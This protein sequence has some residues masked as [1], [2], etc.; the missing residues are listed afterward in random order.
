MI[1][2]HA[3]ITIKRGSAGEFEAALAG[4]RAIIAQA[5]GF[6]FLEWYR[7]I[8]FPEKYLLR[9]G[10]ETLEDHTVGFRQSER[11]AQ[12]RALIG[13]FFD[14]PPQVVHFQPI[15]GPT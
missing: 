15:D 10:W 2:E 3:E 12:Y 4:A 7:G 14:S 13:E 1:L 9:I 5:R 8:E 6:V 11:F